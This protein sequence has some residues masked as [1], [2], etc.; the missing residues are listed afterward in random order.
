MKIVFFTAILMILAVVGNF[1]QNQ[2]QKDK[3]LEELTRKQE[4]ERNDRDLNEKIS[5]QI[6]SYNDMPSPPMLA[7]YLPANTENAW[8]IGILQYIGWSEI[9]QIKTVIKSDGNFLCQNDKFEKDRIVLTEN[10][11]F[12]SNLINKNEFSKLKSDDSLISKCNQCT[13]NWLVLLRKREITIKKN[14]KQVQTESYKFNL[15]DHTTNLSPIRR[16]Y[17]TA[18]SSANCE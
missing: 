4:I 8:A 15:K 3:D 7:E 9:T 11:E 16:I 13:S 17:D 1:A 10:F 18:L 6:S 5:A 14:K 2:N 12:L